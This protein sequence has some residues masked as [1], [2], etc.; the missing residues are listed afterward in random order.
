MKLLP[1]W[2]WRTVSPSIHPLCWPLSFAPPTPTLGKEPLSE[3][4]FCFFVFF[5]N[6]PYSYCF[7]I[8][9]PHIYYVGYVL[10]MCS[11][12]YKGHHDVC[13]LLW[14]ATFVQHYVF[15]IQHSFCVC[16]LG[17]CIL[18]SHSV[19]YP[20]LRKHPNST[21]YSLIDGAALVFKSALNMLSP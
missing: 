14:L 6:L 19:S 21:I 9:L 20:V 18:N 11:T 13:I 16:S 17:P 3:C 10:L 2:K 7:I 15:G 5:L 12:L 8:V 4:C 1:N